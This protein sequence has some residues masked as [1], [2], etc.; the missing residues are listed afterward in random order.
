M[1]SLPWFRL[2]HEFASDPVIQ[3]LAF[4]DQRHYV[5]ILCLKCSGVLDRSIDARARNRIILRGLG[6]DAVAAEEAK[7]RLSEVGLIDKTWQPTGWE[8]RQYESDNSTSRV[9]KYRKEKKIG[10]VTETPEKRF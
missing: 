2:Y 6:L 8:G 3:S 5:V 10:N 1:P 9:R 7:R 4:E